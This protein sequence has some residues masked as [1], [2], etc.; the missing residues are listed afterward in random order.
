V[1][2]GNHDELMEQKG[3]YFQMYQLQQGKTEK[4]AEKTA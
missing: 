1:E 3:R 4:R 2:R